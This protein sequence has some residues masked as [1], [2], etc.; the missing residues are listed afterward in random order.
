[1]RAKWVLGKINVTSHKQKGHDIVGVHNASAEEFISACAGSNV[2]YDWTSENP[3][4][5]AKA[6]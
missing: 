4:C 1:M 3:F 2:N 5:K 6:Q